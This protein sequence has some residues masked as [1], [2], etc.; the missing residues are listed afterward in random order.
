[1]VERKRRTDEETKDL[2][3]EEW[4]EG[5]CVTY[6]HRER[7][8]EEKKKREGGE[9]GR[10]KNHMSTHMCFHSQYAV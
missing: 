4:F 9:V 10:L 3:V 5:E 7:K 8:I 2:M 6:T 1:M